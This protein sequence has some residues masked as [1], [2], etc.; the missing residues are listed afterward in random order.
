[1]K[2]GSIFGFNLLLV[3]FLCIKHPRP[4][5]PAVASAQRSQSASWQ[6]LDKCYSVFSGRK[7]LGSWDFYRGL[8]IRRTHRVRT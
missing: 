4:R 2:K 6:R 5:F 3:S 7:P 1:M 8:D